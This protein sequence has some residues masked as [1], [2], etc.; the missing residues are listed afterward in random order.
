MM[1]ELDLHSVK[2]N[3]HAKD[4]RQWSFHSKVIV[5]THTHTHI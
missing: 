4:L 1:S 2:D 5:W 3:Q